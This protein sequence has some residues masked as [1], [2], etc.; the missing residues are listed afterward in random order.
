MCL[1][2]VADKTFAKLGDWEESCNVC[3]RECVRACMCG[4]VCVCVCACVCMCVCVCTCAYVCVCVREREQT[5]KGERWREEK[6]G[7]K[8]HV[9]HTSPSCVR[10]DFC[11]AII[12]FSQWLVATMN[13]S[14]RI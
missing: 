5:E 9:H 14:T 1:K 3:V 10:V 13:I 12:F 8:L 2:L 11:H 6:A 7:K 4:C